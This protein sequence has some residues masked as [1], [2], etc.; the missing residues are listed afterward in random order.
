[1]DVHSSTYGGFCKWGYPSSWM[2]YFMENPTKIA[3]MYDLGIAPT[4]WKPGP[5][6]MIQP[7]YGMIL[8]IYNILIGFDLSG[9]DKIDYDRGT[10]IK[11]SFIDPM[12]CNP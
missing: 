4:C 6:G 3:K 5:Y 2:V 9:S 12:T 11:P 1:M 7:P 10:V 8:Y